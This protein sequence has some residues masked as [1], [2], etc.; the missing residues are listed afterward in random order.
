M[1]RKMPGRSTLNKKASQTTRYFNEKI[2]NKLVC[3][4]LF[5]E[6]SNAKSLQEILYATGLVGDYDGQYNTEHVY[7]VSAQRSRKQMAEYLSN[8]VY[9]CTL[10]E[11]V[12]LYDLVYSEVLVF[13]ETETTKYVLNNRGL[14]D[15]IDKIVSIITVILSWLLKNYRDSFPKNTYYVF[16]KMG[17]LKAFP[18][19]PFETYRCGANPYKAVA[20]LV[21]HIRDFL[22]NFCYFNYLEETNKFMRK[23]LRMDFE[24]TLFDDYL[25]RGM[26]TFYRETQSS[27]QGLVYKYIP[28]FPRE[29]TEIITNYILPSTR[30]NMTLLEFAELCPYVGTY[31]DN[32]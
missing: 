17:F 6:C 31:L 2:R 32:I 29:M 8:Y 20:D 16:E 11:L 24:H 12:V 10:P 23:I 30:R 28:L 5:D 15:K 19:V 9:E 13:Q 27:I 3:S 26:P 22:T 7:I 4:I 21:A 25:P 1:E 18:G 14:T